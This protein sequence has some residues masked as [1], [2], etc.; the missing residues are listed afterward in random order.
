[1]KPANRES[2]ALLIKDLDTREEIQLTEEEKKRMRRECAVIPANPCAVS[3]DGGV[4][5]RAKDDKVRQHRH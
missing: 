5:A 1:M 2:C 3:L 4:S